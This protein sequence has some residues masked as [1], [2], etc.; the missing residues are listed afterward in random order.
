MVHKGFVVKNIYVLINLI[1][2]YLERPLAQNPLLRRSSK[3]H[4]I[5]T[6]IFRLKITNCGSHQ[7]SC[8]VGIEPIILRAG[9]AERLHHLC[10]QHFKYISNRQVK[11]QIL[12]AILDI[13]DK[14]MSLLRVSM[15]GDSHL[16]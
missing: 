2:I 1:F 7:V 8:Y 5:D 15:A 16:A 12:V 4:K 9:E 6:K 14:I 10:F 13:F 11:L 3:I